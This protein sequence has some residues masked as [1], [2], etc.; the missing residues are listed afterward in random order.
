MNSLSKKIIAKIKQ[1]KKQGYNN[2]E[3]SLKLK[4]SM[5]SVKK[6]SATLKIK[7]NT[8]R[9]GRPRKLSLD[10][11]LELC[12]QYSKCKLPSLS[13]GKELIFKNYNIKVSRQHIKNVLNKN[14]LYCKVKQKKPLLTDSHKS[15]RHEFATIYKNFSYFDWKN[16][17]WSDESKYALINTNKKEYYWAEKKSELSE[18][19]IKK[20]KKFGGGSVMVWGCITG[21]GVGEL[22]RI[23][24]N[25]DTTK[26]I[27]ILGDGLIKTIEKHDINEKKVIFQQDNAPPHKSKTTLDWLKQNKIKVLNWPAQSPD[28]NPIENLWEI[29]DKK[30]RKNEIQPKNCDELWEIIKHEWNNIDLNI[31]RSLYLSMTKRIQA[32]YDKKGGYTKY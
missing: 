23:D 5:T 1:L 8:A 2:K 12:K 9:K 11:E 3:I 15:K 30:I 29:I 6:Y 19:Q 25:I 14:N 22:I 18:T 4:V 21:N 16:V 31:I 13:M 24:G 27:K 26:Y 17:I 32:V 20:T 7:H 10:Q 28:L